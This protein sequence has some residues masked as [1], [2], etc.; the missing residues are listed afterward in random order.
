MHVNAMSV[1][2]PDLH[3]QGSSARSSAYFEDFGFAY[4]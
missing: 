3:A 4:P 2:V 1:Y